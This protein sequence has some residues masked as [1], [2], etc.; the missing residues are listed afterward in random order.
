MCIGRKKKGKSKVL[1][2]GFCLRDSEAEQRALRFLHIHRS[3]VN[4][5]SSAPESDQQN[6]RDITIDLP[7]FSCY[8]QITSHKNLPSPAPNDNLPHWFQGSVAVM[9][10]FDYWLREFPLYVFASRFELRCER[11]QLMLL[12]YKICPCLTRLVVRLWSFHFV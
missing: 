3:N 10:I 1:S 5:Y 9:F 7:F 8:K 6:P 4:I 2:D 12:Y 11:K